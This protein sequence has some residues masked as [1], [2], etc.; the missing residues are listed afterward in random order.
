MRSEASA[1]PRLSW[2]QGLG[3]SGVGKAHKVT[4]LT[5]QSEAE[6]LQGQRASV[7]LRKFSTQKAPWADRK[8]SGS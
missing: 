6:D 8:S 7:D 1:P 5:I 2:R 4:T 3:H